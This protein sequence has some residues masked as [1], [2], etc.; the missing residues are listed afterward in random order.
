MNKKPKKIKS[1]KRTVGT[2]IPDQSFTKLT[3]YCLIKNVSKSQVI[4]NAILQYQEKMNMN[5][6]ILIKEMSRKLQN[7]WEELSHKDDHSAD[8]I[9]DLFD[10]FVGA[11]RWHLRSKNI[12]VEIIDKIINNINK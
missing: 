10:D 3:L 2:Y 9:D 4:A 1:Q 5:F 11:Q 8:N 6:D 7:E 12:P